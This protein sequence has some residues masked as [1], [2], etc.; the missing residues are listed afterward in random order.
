MKLKKKFEK[1]VV[2]FVISPTLVLRGKFTVHM[3]VVLYVDVF[4][5][6]TREQVWRAFC[7]REYIY[8]L[9]A[10]FNHAVFRVLNLIEPMNNF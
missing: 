6:V 4:V 9:H 3:Q 10:F 1:E 7:L 5:E 8:V 2:V